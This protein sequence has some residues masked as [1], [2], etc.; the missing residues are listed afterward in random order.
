M[1]AIAERIAAYHLLD[2]GALRQIMPEPLVVYRL[3]EARRPNV[4]VEVG[5]A[6]GG[7]LYLYA[8]ACAPD[9]LV[10]AIDNGRKAASLARVIDVLRGQ[11]YDARWLRGNS[12]SAGLQKVLA[13]DLAGRPVDFL[14]I[15]GDHSRDGVMADWRAYSPLVRTGGLIALHDVKYA[16][17]GCGVPTA[18]AEIRA[19]EP[20]WC[21]VVGPPSP[22]VKQRIGIGLIWR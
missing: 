11:G 17:P 19:G 9:A 5:S 7:S 2:V 15:D 14:H 8:G 6:S 21:E 3:V 4:F 12:H 22:R 10:V 1:N 16:K 13:G 18:W 20:S